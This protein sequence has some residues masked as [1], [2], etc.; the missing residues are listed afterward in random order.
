[1]S[2]EGNYQDETSSSTEKTSQDKNSS[3]ETRQ[4]FF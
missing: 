1:M 4:K 3:E 2:S